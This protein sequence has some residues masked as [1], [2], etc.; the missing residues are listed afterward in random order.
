MQLQNHR[1]TH[2]LTQVSTMSPDVVY[3]VTMV[4]LK[5]GR[6]SSMNKHGA[7]APNFLVSNPGFATS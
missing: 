2:S 6:Y 5:E 4:R 1:Q 3:M 7:L